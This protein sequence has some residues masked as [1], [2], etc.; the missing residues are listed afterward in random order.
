MKIAKTVLEVLCLALLQLAYSGLLAS[1]LSAER[2]TLRIGD[3]ERTFSICVPKAYNDTQTPIPLVLVLHGGGGNA[4]QAARPT[5]MNEAA[6][7]APFIAV[8]PEG[9]A[10]KESRLLTWN[11]GNC[12]GY[13]YANQM[14]DVG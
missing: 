3:L 14:D 1:S 10:R 6:D 12:C 4:D 8:F 5:G 2:R 13:A 11:A 7:K 9:T